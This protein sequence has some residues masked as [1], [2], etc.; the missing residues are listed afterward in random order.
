MY[1]MEMIFQHRHCLELFHANRTITPNLPWL[2]LFFTYWCMIF[3]YV[4]LWFTSTL[5]IISTLYE[6]NKTMRCLFM[7][8]QGF[9]F[10]T[11]ISGRM[12]V[13]PLFFFHCTTTFS[14]SASLEGFLQ[15]TLVSF[16]CFPIIINRSCV[17][18]AVLQTPPLLI[19]WLSNP[20]WKYLQNTFTPKPW[21]LGSWHFEVRFTSP[22]QSCVM[23]HMSC[24][25]CHM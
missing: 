25:T 12:T 15:T 5:T 6:L 11:L 9:S 22:L 4:I 19:N 24:V 13:N 14:P 16:L 18:R 20:F 3:I 8:T 21:E 1:F 17:T 10:F 7:L 23:C 2:M